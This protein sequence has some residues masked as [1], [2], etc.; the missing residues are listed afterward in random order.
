[1]K[2]GG[3]EARSIYTEYIN[4]AYEQDSEELTGEEKE[5]REKEIESLSLLS[6][7]MPAML[8][9]ELGEFSLETALRSGGGT[10]GSVY[11]R[12]HV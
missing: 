3:K 1:M 12:C 8:V 6:S 7:S 9:A 2:P 4:Q 11:L 10:G 5:E